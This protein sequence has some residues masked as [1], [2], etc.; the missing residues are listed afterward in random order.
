MHD[1]AAVRA[2]C[3]R[4]SLFAQNIKIVRHTVCSVRA[5]NNEKMQASQLEIISSNEVM[6]NVTILKALV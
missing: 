6:N 2:L 5:T 1:K 4:V 3:K